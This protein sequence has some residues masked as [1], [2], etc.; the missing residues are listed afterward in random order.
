MPFFEVHIAFVFSEM[1]YTLVAGYAVYK[2]K[3]SLK[4]QTE[5]MYVN[6]T[7]KICHSSANYPGN[8]YYLSGSSFLNNN[9]IV[10]CGG[11][12]GKG[13]RTSDC[14]S[15]SNDLKWTHFANL[16][17]RRSG[18]AAVVVKNGLWVT[19]NGKRNLAL[20]QFGYVS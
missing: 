16:T 4:T 18:I 13:L 20:K 15:M 12:L 14:Y 7:T 8:V 3:K 5:V 2:K 6:G 10:A 1:S 11:Y 17:G 9:T 19:G